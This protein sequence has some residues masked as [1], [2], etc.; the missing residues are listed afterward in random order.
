MSKK[1]INIL[2][3]ALFIPGGILFSLIITY[4]FASLI[5]LIFNLF[6]MNP[7]FDSGFLRIVLNLAVS[8]SM[9]FG[10]Y[11]IQPKTK[12]TVWISLVSLWV[13]AE[14][15]GKIWVQFLPY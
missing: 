7:N 14:I 1:T 12:Y 3:W 9:F 2:R 15:F 6:S 13:I 8:L 11:K 4:I 10:F 5:I